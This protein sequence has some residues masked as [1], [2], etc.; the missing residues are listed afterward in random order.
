[1]V[2]FIP[3]AN[4]IKVNF[5]KCISLFSKWW[6]CLSGTQTSH[7]VP[8]LHGTTPLSERLPHKL[9]QSDDC[10]IPSDRTCICSSVNYSVCSIFTSLSGDWKPLA[11][12]LSAAPAV[13]H[14]QSLVSQQ[15]YF[16]THYNEP[17]DKVCS[18]VDLEI[19]NRTKPS[20]VQPVSPRDGVTFY[21]YFDRSLSPMTTCPSHL[22]FI[23]T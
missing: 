13:R 18:S 22:L 1:M 17:G 2:W 5:T 21:P 8:R 6:V 12:P 9:A 11:S 7:L 3:A 15:A 16:L 10:W 4:V 14:H 20:A 23:Q 19:C